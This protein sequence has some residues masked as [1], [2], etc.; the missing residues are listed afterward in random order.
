MRITAG[1]QVQE[2]VKAQFGE[3]CE[4]GEWSEGVHVENQLQRLF[5]G[6]ITKTHDSA[7]HPLDF[8]KLFQRDKE[9]YEDALTRLQELGISKVFSLS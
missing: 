8:G 3:S 4:M 5:S 7:L 9:G 6:H 2:K 1:F